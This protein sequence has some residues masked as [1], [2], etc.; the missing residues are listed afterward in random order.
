MNLYLK[1]KDKN[2]KI[3]LRNFNEK[4]LIISN[5]S[6]YILIIDVKDY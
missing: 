3:D 5:D 1:A 2:Q 6:N 4:K